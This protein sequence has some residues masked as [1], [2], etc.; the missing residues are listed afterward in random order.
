MGSIKVDKTIQKA[1]GGQ[2]GTRPIIESQLDGLS[3]LLI[4]VEA[5]EQADSTSHASDVASLEVT[6]VQTELSRIAT[7]TESTLAE[8]QREAAQFDKAVDEFNA[9]A[10]R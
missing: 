3:L 10:I 4:R 6:E 7:S 2:D 1:C 8:L 5:A 9:A